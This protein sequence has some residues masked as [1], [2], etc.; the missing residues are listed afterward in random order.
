MSDI[1][2]I[3]RNFSRYASFYDDYSGVQNRVGQKLI[4][5]VEQN[6]FD[7]ILDVGCGTGNYTRLLCRQF[8]DAAVK[9]LDI[10]PQMISIA[11][12]KLA[13]NKIEFMI[14]D[15]ETAVFNRTFDLITSNAC[16][17]W[18]DNTETVIMNYSDLL[19]DN[20]TILFSVFGPQ[21]FHRLR[22]CLERLYKKEVRTS[23]SGFITAGEIEQILGKYFNDFFVEEQ[24]I[25]ETYDSL[26]SLLNTI[27]YT[28]T[29]G[30]GIEGQNITRGQI[31]ELERIYKEEF[32]TITAVYQ[33]F[34]CRAQKGPNT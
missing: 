2:T 1:E 7:K 5:F 3:K 21:T 26:W 13:G 17:Q 12:R 33:I 15:A 6:S 4:D 16:F 9:A 30:D 27:K 29:Q 23:S 18:F 31:T 10:C 28:G 11:E 8:P 22:R 32:K 24:I 19:N 25:E 34:Y 20:G 14:A